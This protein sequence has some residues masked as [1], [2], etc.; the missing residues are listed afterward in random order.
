[1]DN[2][3][4]SG[5]KV[6]EYSGFI[7]GPYC[8]KLLADLGAK[9][10]KIE[11]PGLGDKARSWGPFPQDIPHPEK[12]GLF[13]H[14]NTNKLGVTLN[15]RSQA[16]LN[17]FRELVKL[18][19]IIVE[20]NTPQEMKEI[21]LDYENLQKI[22]P[23]AV[24][25]SIT[26]FGQTRPY[27]AYKSCDLINNHMSGEAY[28]NPESGADDIEQQP[29]LN[30]P[31]H[32]SDYYAGLI[33]AINTMSAVIARQV[34][35]LGQHVDL[36]QQEAIAYILCH[37]FDNYF[38]SGVSFYRETSRKSFLTSEYA[39][40]NGYI[41]I[42][43]FTD[44]FWASLVNMMGNPDWTKSEAFR[45]AGSRRKHLGIIKPKVKDWM[46]EHTIEEINQL[47]KANRAACVPIQTVK[48]AVNSE[49]L[50]ARGYFVEV[51]HK[52]AGK[53]KFPGAPYKF[54]ETPWKVKRPA[55]LLGEHNNEVYCQ[56]LGY[57]R[58]E[59]VKMKQ[60]GVI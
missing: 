29:P 30:P 44:A 20:N 21:G 40:K 55:P 14:L 51:D 16:G 10:I 5:L 28:T 36:S 60:A 6:I 31:G 9:V 2:E 32:A 50:A 11:P 7:S 4:L 53:I 23:A 19:D 56:M 18:V 8:G 58:E 3:A 47:A 33:A 45:T 15:L 12:S 27:R 42:S 59:L 38:D 57:A 34:T 49:L 46:G 43:T 35:G 24:V 54:S 37:E 22:N 1:V 41:M 25:T 48:E 52:E 26:P 13:L 39:C 17:I